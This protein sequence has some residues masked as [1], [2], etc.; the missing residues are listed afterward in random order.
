MTVIGSSTTIT[1]T[2]TATDLQTSGIGAITVFNPA[3]WRR[4]KQYAQ[5]SITGNTATPTSTPTGTIT[6]NPS[7][8][9]FTLNPG[10]ALPGDAG[11]WVRISGTGFIST[12]Q[13]R[14]NGGNR[15]TL[16]IDSSTLDIF[17]TSTDLASAGS[18]AVTVS[19]ST[20]G[21][22]TS[23]AVNLVV[24]SPSATPTPTRTPTGTLTSHAHA[25]SHRHAESHGDY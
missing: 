22:G 5:L 18:F 6:A 25:D 20:P 4:H 1:M 14:W 7:P 23:N 11:Q 24:A 13:A 15:S 17:V 16:Y 12:S 3:S 9:V 2:V 8:F 21:G 10:T 19:N